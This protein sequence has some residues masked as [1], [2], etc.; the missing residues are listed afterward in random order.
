MAPGLGTSGRLQKLATSFAE[1]TE[2]ELEA[3]AVEG[4]RL[5]TGHPSDRLTWIAW[6]RHSVIFIVLSVD[7]AFVDGVA[8]S[9]LKQI[10]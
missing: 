10:R 5:Y 1:V 6:A 9:V 4:E 3:R 8:R 7:A 2:C